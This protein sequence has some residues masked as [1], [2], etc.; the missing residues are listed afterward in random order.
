MNE[1]LL[2]QLASRAQ[3]EKEMVITWAAAM[4]SRMGIA[5]IVEEDNTT[6]ELE[7]EDE[8]P[9]EVKRSGISPLEYFTEKKA[10]ENLNNVDETEDDISE[11]LDV[12]TNCEKTNNVAST[13][14]NHLEENDDSEIDVVNGGPSRIEAAEQ[15]AQEDL[16]S[17]TE[18]TGECNPKILRPSENNSSQYGSENE[19]K[20]A[21]IEPKV[22]EDAGEISIMEK[23]ARYDNMT[24]ELEEMKSKYDS[25]FKLLAVKPEPKPVQQPWGWNTPQ[26]QGPYNPY[27]LHQPGFYNLPYPPPDQGSIY[28][29][30]T[31]YYPPPNYNLPYPPVDNGSI[32]PPTYHPGYPPQPQN[33]LPYPPAL[34]NF[35]TPFPPTPHNDFQPQ[36]PE[37][38]NQ[39]SLPYPSNIQIGHGVGNLAFFQQQFPTPH[40][41]E[42]PVKKFEAAQNPPLTAC[43]QSPTTA[44]TTSSQPIPTPQPLSEGACSTE[45][46]SKEEACLPPPAEEEMS[47]VQEEA[48]EDLQQAETDGFSKTNSESKE[49]DIL[50]ED[51]QQAETIV[52]TGVASLVN[53]KDDEIIGAD[54]EEGAKTLNVK[55]NQE[56]TN[57]TDSE[58]YEEEEKMIEN[59]IAL[60]DTTVQ[61][62]D[63]TI[64]LDDTIAPK[65]NT[66][67]VLQDAAIGKDDVEC[68]TSEDNPAAEKSAEANWDEIEGDKDDLTGAIMVYT[69]AHNLE[70]AVDEKEEDLLS[71]EDQDIESFIEQHKEESHAD[72]LGS[73]KDSS[74]ILNSTTNPE[75]DSN[76]AT[77]SRHNVTK[78]KLD[79][80]D[81]KFDGETDDE[82]EDFFEN[83]EVE[84]SPEERE[85]QE[86]LMMEKELK[87]EK[88]RAKVE[89]EERKK[90]FAL[91]R[92]RNEEFKISEKKRLERE[93]KE[94]EEKARMEAEMRRKEMEALKL[95][96]AEARRERKLREME[97]QRR[98]KEEIMRK[99]VE[100]ETARQE[101]MRRREEEKRL[102]EE[103]KANREA[104]RRLALEKSGKQSRRDLMKNL[105]K[106]PQYHEE[107][108]QGGDVVKKR[109]RYQGG[110]EEVG[111]ERWAMFQNPQAKRQQQDFKMEEEGEE[112]IQE[113]PR[114]RK[115][116]VHTLFPPIIPIFAST[117]APMM[118]K[119]FPG[120]WPGSDP[121]QVQGPHLRAG[122]GHLVPPKK[123]KK[124]EKQ[125]QP[126]IPNLPRGLPGIAISKVGSNLI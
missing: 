3:M 25:L 30:Y 8:V 37:S 81:E 13:E 14:E 87:E 48:S 65:T 68:V 60:C 94:R 64:L 95:K 101:E 34:S 40:A 57:L 16:E 110:E 42:K 51:E 54:F 19:L 50:E 21:D 83:D 98:M 55:D 71:H 10:K 22:E 82:D 43:T 111:M 91:W 11:S 47:R 9:E 46:A 90:K 72:N 2:S 1:A 75:K 69:G 32:Y 52:E 102:R 24:R 96:E 126:I 113:V 118:S 27:P 78:K 12:D 5:R 80:P 104:A 84:L 77:D 62:N 59:A 103:E 44:Q 39:F 88:A 120:P 36:R 117:P 33:N 73:W 115:G 31:N 89:E 63:T 6:L 86:L 76:Q 70:D 124:P 17:N 23:A 125:T 38:T 45:P 100:E 58:L 93:K 53:G 108:E 119:Q 4:R 28:P 109:P 97:E 66:E 85:R 49:E 35:P 56:D 123:K 18:V 7:E 116:R 41:I 26:Q 105:N 107:E 74:K 112:E 67:D 79:A 15:K 61:L 121:N 92:Q 29:S 20:A 99:K 106:R 122:Q 114:E